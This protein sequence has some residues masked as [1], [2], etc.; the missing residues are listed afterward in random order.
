MH[1]TYPYPGK[2]SPPPPHHLAPGTWHL[3]TQS[4][5]LSVMPTCLSHL[6][7]HPLF[8]CTWYRI[9]HSLPCLDFSREYW[10]LLELLGKYP[11]TPCPRTI[12]PESSFIKSRRASSPSAPPSRA[13]IILAAPDDSYSQLSP[14]GFACASRLAAARQI[15]PSPASHARSLLS[16]AFAPH[17]FRFDESGSVRLVCSFRAEACGSGLGYFAAGLLRRHTTPAQ[18]ATIDAATVGSPPPLLSRRTTTALGFQS[19]RAAKSSRADR[20]HLCAY[21][22]CDQPSNAT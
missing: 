20:L 17:S 4:V 1:R 3:R 7:V 16:L 22:P 14:Q 2:L 6:S 8:A 12:L 10:V 9:G 15:S 19:S 13:L 11:S 5:C 21:A 18:S